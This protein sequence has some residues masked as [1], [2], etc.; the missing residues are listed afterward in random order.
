MLPVILGGDGRSR[1]LENHRISALRSP[2]LSRPRGRTPRRSVPVFLA[3][4]C[5]W[6]MVCDRRR[7]LA[8]SEHCLDD[9]SALVSPA[10]LVEAGVADRTPDG[11]DYGGDSPFRLSR[12]RTESDRSIEIEH[13]GVQIR[14][15]RYVV[16][17]ERLFKSDGR[18]ADAGN[19]DLLVLV[20]PD[21]D[22]GNDQRIAN[23]PVRYIAHMA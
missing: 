14:Y 15:W 12:S 10:T 23:R 20:L 17:P 16:V 18:A 21:G 2:L 7:R 19:G 5:A 3:R 1:A 4:R 9:G 22:T 11:H 6:A 8:R 13:V